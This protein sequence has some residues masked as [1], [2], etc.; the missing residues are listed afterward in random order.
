[1]LI[2]AVIM[3]GKLNCESEVRYK[4]KAVVEFS[5]YESEKPKK[6]HERLKVVC[7]EDVFHVSMFVIGQ[8][9]PK[10]MLKLLH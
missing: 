4:Q 5:T 2:S 8:V 7:A 1:M 9:R 3:N 6:I 10:K